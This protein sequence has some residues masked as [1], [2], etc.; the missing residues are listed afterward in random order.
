[1]KVLMLLL[2]QATASGAVGLSLGMLLETT[3]FIIRMNMP[4]SLDVRYGHLLDKK[5]DKQQA[6]SL[7]EA[8]LAVRHGKKGDK[9]VRDKV[10]IIETKKRL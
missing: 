8:S 2:L 1:M 9:P 7:G 10:V 3:L 6:P 5:Y 4:E